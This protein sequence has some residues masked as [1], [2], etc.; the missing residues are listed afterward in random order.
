ME[1]DIEAER[2]AEK[3][4]RWKAPTAMVLVQLFQ[5]GMILLSKVSIS[6][7]MFIFALLAYRSFFGVAIIFPFALFF[8][9]GKWKEM[10]RRACGWIFFNAFIG[11]AVPMSFYFYGLGDTT[12][13]YAV[14]Y[15][16]LIPLVTFI[17][18]LL[19]RL[20]SLQ[21]GA[22]V[23]WLKIGG[24]LLSVGGTM[25]ISLYKGKVLHLWPSIIQH[26]KDEHVE[27]ARHQLRGTIFLVGSTITFACWYLI[28]GKVLKVY[29]YKYWSSMA[30][31][32]VGGF[33][34]LLIGTI[35]RRDKNAWKLGWDIQLVTVIYTGALSTAGKY[36]LNSW[37]VAK[38]GPAYP[39][40]FSPL[41]MVFTV[42]LGSIFIGDEITIGSLLGT[43]TVIVG[44]YVFLWAKAKELHDI[45]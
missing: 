1:M 23:G 44:L 21:F 16:N 17:L 34:T 6:E 33:Q 31:C 41:S 13:S 43:I 15:T 28:Q 39:P 19:L 11:Y 32:L 10:D 25:V 5:T 45:I 14:I 42:V 7:G 12:A 8:E 20:E 36:C 2:K 18:S 3:A 26:H 4:L 37:G 38:K 30:T 9:R 35:L 22:A 24:V 40:M 27:V 29:P